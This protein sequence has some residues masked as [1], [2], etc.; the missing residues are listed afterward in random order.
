M[1]M[2]LKVFIFVMGFVVLTY[3]LRNLLNRGRSGQAQP[4]QSGQI[5]SGKRTPQKKQAI[6]CCNHCGIFVPEAEIVRGRLGDYC[7][8]EHRALDEDGSR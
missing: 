2:L 6:T 8:K 3:W 1:G 7:C 4:P 5:F